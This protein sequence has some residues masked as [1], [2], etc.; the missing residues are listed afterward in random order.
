MGPV[1][2][3]DRA[4]CLEILMADGEMDH[5]GAEEFF[6]FNVAGSYVGERTPMFLETMAELFPDDAPNDDPTAK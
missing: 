5:E 2:V 4:K 6:E 3:Y 1:V